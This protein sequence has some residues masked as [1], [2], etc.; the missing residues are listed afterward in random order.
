[1][2]ILGIEALTPDEVRARVAAGG[3]FVLFEYCVSL[4]FVTL[5]RPGCIRFVKPGKDTLVHGL[6]YTLY[7]LLLGWWGI[8]WGLVYTPAVLYTNLRGGRDVTREVL[9]FLQEA[10]PSWPGGTEPEE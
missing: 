10:G 9:A 5:R 1:V 2:R 6:P 3:R 8:P 7:T 4:I